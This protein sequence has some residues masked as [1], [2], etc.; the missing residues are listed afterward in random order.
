MSKTRRE[1]GKA[2][3]FPKAM[4]VSPSMMES[5]EFEADIVEDFRAY[6]GNAK[7]G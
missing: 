1:E 6:I 5:G 4:A 3:E 2:Q 7:G